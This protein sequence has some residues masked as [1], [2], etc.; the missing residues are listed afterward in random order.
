LL[1]RV[2]TLIGHLRSLPLEIN[3]W[4]IQNTYFSVAGAA[5]RDISAKAKTG[6][7]AAK[8]WVE[9]FRRMGELLSFSTS[10]I[11]PEG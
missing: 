5:Y 1:E 11:L 4:Q 8:K 6:D 2:F 7:D 9:T 10:A 3:F